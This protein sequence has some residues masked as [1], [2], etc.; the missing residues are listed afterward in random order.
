MKVRRITPGAVLPGGIVRV[1]VEGLQGVLDLRAEIGEA[2]AE[3]VGASE[4]VLTLRASQAPA[5]QGLLISQGGN[6][7]RAALKVGRVVASELHSVA[8]PAVDP[9]GTVYCT[10]SGTR[11][12]KVPFCVF[13]IDAAG[14]KQPFLADLMNPTGLAWGPDDHLYISSRQT[15][16]VYRSSPDKRVE[17]YV[18]GLGLATGIAFDSAGNLYVGDRS[19]TIHRVS[20][21]R[22]ISAFCELEPSV[23]AYHL[24]VAP[25]DTLFVTGPTLSTQDCVYRV[26]P[27]GAVEVY[28][29]GFG[30]PQGLA[31]DVR[32]DLQV[33][34]SFEGKKGIYT[35]KDGVPEWTISSPMLVGLAYNSDRSVLYLVDSS[36]LFAL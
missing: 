9:D 17:K 20:P 27:S 2:E 22:Q 29:K 5:G 26:Q 23:S 11:G 13:A 1:E 14:V 34:A 18:D 6:R 19:G 15:G 36:H 24:A 21:D 12:E 35:L 30:R 31:F 3:F 28:F 10:F 8:N 16:A 33:A 7:A 25:D 32:G 4:T